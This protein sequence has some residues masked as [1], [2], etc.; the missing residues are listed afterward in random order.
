V[1]GV[2]VAVA[3]LVGVPVGVGVA[4]GELRAERD[5]VGDGELDGVG[6]GE[7]GVAGAVTVEEGSGEPAGTGVPVAEGWLVSDVVTS[8]G[9]GGGGAAAS[10]IPAVIIAMLPMAA[11][12]SSTGFQGNGCFGPD[13]GPS[14]VTGGVPDSGPSAV[15]GCLPVVRPTHRSSARW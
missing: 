4:E 5:G 9:A 11:S 8:T 6:G 10:A 15:T 13:S 7:L 12:P 14:A 1:V 3:V 2:G